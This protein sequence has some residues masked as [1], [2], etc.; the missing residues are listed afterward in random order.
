MAYRSLEDVRSEAMVDHVGIYISDTGGKHLGCKHEKLA[1]ETHSYSYALFSTVKSTRSTR[2]G[3]PGNFRGF[4]RLD[5]GI[6]SDF[7]YNQDHLNRNFTERLYKA[8]ICVRSISV[9][10][11]LIVTIPSSLSVLLP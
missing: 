7:Y 6:D 3:A 2:R 5:S 10:P 1:I 11:S 8:I 9:K 4:I